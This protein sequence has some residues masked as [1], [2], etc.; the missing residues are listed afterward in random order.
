MAEKS[1]SYSLIIKNK[2]LHDFYSA[3]PHINF[4][5]MNL[6]LLGFLEQ[7]NNDISKLSNL[8]ATGEILN[9]VKDIKHGLATISDSV[10]LN[11]NEH[12]AR[13]LETTKLVIGMASSENTDKIM[14]LLNRNTDSFIER[15]NTSIPKTQDD[16]SRRIQDSLAAAQAA[17][18]TDIKGFLSSNNSDTTLKEFM[19]ALEQR[20]TQ[21]QQPLC[22]YITAQQD[23]LAAQLSNIKDDA[24]VNRT[25]SDKLFTELG[26]FLS[27]YK[28]S[29]QFKGQC[30][31]NMLEAV[32]NKLMPTADVANTTAIKA[33]GDFIIRREDKPTILIENK[34][35]ERNVNPEE[36]KKFLRDVVEQRCSG[37]MMSQFSGIASKPNGF[38]EIHDTNVLV[39]LHNVDYSPDKIK[40]A[41]D[42]ID[43]LSVKLESISAQEETTGIVI[44]KDVLDRI[45]EQFQTFMTQRDAVL[46]TLRES[47]KKTVSQIEDMK[48]PELSLFLN[49][50]YAS[51]Q[52][53][54]FLCDV[55]N[56]AF[57]TKRSLASHKKM[58]KTR[59]NDSIGVVATAVS[60]GAG[61]VEG[62][63]DDDD[64]YTGLL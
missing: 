43:N 61:G 37:I 51:I 16:A 15:L 11:L 38:I 13:F 57:T 59:S 45:N 4:E 48:L 55:C 34:N 25:V 32:L 14:Q 47:H 30:S 24:L 23:Q 26:E 52:N 7:L 9:C 41:I 46:A 40:M 31:E 62:D 42:V 12:N 39:Y 22:A 63:N 10:V 8:T 54:Q 6:I 19:V 58:H 56:A 1:Q 60:G 33:S 21:Q 17:I 53:Q 49:D 36:T 44:K 3:N 29:S 27:K 50:K 20:L 64:A 35:Y 5:A 18:Q 28:S 2:R